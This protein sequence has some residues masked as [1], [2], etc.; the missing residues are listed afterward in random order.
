PR[1]RC[2]IELLSGNSRTENNYDIPLN[3]QECETR[4]TRSK[5][6]VQSKTAIIEEIIDSPHP[7]VPHQISNK[8]NHEFTRFE[9]G[10]IKNIRLRLTVKK[11]PELI[12]K[13]LRPRQKKNKK[14]SVF[15]DSEASLISTRSSDLSKSI[16]NTSSLKF[17]IS[18]Q[19]D[20]ESLENVSLKP[21]VPQNQQI[22][23]THI[24][25]FVSDD[26]ISACYQNELTNRQTESFI[27][28]NEIN[29]PSFKK[30][31]CEDL[32]NLVKQWD[33]LGLKSADDLSEDSY[34]QR[35]RK[36]EFAEKR[37]KNREEERL[38]HFLYKT[39]VEQ[40]KQEYLQ[41]NN[42]TSPAPAS[43]SK[44]KNSSDTDPVSR[45]SLVRTR[46]TIPYTSMRS[47]AINFNT[48]FLPPGL[49]LTGNYLQLQLNQEI[50]VTEQQSEVE[51]ETFNEIKVRKL[52]ETPIIQKDLLPEWVSNGVA[53]KKRLVKAVS[54]GRRLLKYS[55]KNSDVYKK[56]TVGF[57]GLRVRRCL[58]IQTPFGV[59][60]PPMPDKSFERF[61]ELWEIIKEV[62]DQKQNPS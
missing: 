51:L 59:Q 17:S 41:I 33:N 43:K 28:T 38:K 40:E 39:K 8:I 35:H 55:V 24:I 45:R 20:N 56:S 26:E 9:Q 7:V 54:A 58:R 2:F 52:K 1:K 61:P 16:S 21:L 47:Q 57:K 37:I 46:S 6:A 34:E 42:L 29:V 60:M 44:S 53:K 18:E 31:T 11:P 3:D 50:N 22:H 15:C 14:N 32:V 62:S 10:P 12:K 5:S 49:P 48:Q 4:I 25:C 30:F 13:D 36:H 27:G 19:S 23:E